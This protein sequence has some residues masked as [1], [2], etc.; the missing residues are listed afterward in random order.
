MG[1]DREEPARVSG[2][3]ATDKLHFWMSKVVH[4]KAVSLMRRLIRQRAES[5]EALSPESLGLTVGES[6]D[7][8]EWRELLMTRLAEVPTTCW[9]LL[10]HFLDGRPVKDLAAEAGLK[11]GAASHRIRRGIQMLRRHL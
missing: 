1:G 3:R 7:S 6:T 8:G 9:L 4:S 10:G 11:P 2:G 5:L